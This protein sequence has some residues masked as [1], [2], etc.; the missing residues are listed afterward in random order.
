MYLASFFAFVIAALFGLTMAVR[1]FRGRESGTAMGIV[2]GLWALS[3]IVLLAVGLA[4]LNAGLWWWLLAGFVGVALGGLFLF[5]R[6]VRGEPWPTLVLVAHGGAALACIVVLGV[7]LAVR[8][9]PAATGGDV[10]AQTTENETI[11]VEELAPEVE[12]APDAP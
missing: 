7:F 6:Q 9:E 11:P 10:P 12:Q 8:A 2:H 3:G 5:V 1:H 4:Q